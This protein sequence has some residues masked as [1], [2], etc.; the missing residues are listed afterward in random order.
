M[1]IHGCSKCSNK[2]KD[3]RQ[4]CRHDYCFNCCCNCCCCPNEEIVSGNILADTVFTC[5][6]IWLIY[7]EVHVINGATL[8]VNP[9]TIVKFSKGHLKLPLGSSKLPYSSLVVDPGAAINA[10]SVKFYSSEENM[11]G[12][13]IICG[14]SAN[15]FFEVYPSVFSSTA[16]APLQSYLNNVTFDNLGNNESDIN[17]LTL[18]NVVDGGACMGNITILNAG[19]D[20]LEIFGGSHTINSLVIIR[21][22]DDLLDLDLGA[23]LH[24]LNHLE[25]VQDQSFST[26]VIEVIG[27]EGFTN[28]VTVNPH[29]K[30]ILKGPYM[31][32]KLGNYNSGGSFPK[33]IFANDSVD[34]NTFALPGS[35][36][37]A[38][39]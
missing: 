2:K 25:L 19:D 17:A 33:P 13:L 31:S 8:T 14:T 39:A 22:Q 35:F 9:N 3:C 6:K 23:T 5:D 1:A 27:A 10:Q 36:Y 16:V 28:K 32:D 11:S 21:A 30:L 20:G 34:I 26:S 4:N 37:S 15:A 18:F 38:T 29:A 7:G 12:G 24:V